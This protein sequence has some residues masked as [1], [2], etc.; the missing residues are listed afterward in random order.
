MC[1]DNATRSLYSIERLPT[2]RDTSLVRVDPTSGKITL[3]TTIPGAVT[4]GDCYA[5]TA[6]VSGTNN[7][8][9]FIGTVDFTTGAVSTTFILSL[10]QSIQLIN[11]LTQLCHLCNRSIPRSS[12]R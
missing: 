12:T 5:G 3:V 9:T 8:Q 11:N 1:Y 6:F 4:V 2:A 7:G 10:D